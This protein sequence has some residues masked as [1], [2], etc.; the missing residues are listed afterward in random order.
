M[1]G[2][3]SLSDLMERAL[4]KATVIVAALIMIGIVVDGYIQGGLGYG[5][6]S[7][8]NL[9]AMVSNATPVVTVIMLW[10][11][12]RLYY[13]RARSPNVSMKLKGTFFFVG[14]FVAV[15]I[16]IVYGVMSSQYQNLAVVL[17][18]VNDET[19]SYWIAVIFT[20]LVV[21]GALVKSWEGVIIAVTCLAQVW[22]VGGVGNYLLPQL[23]DFGI[24]LM[25]WPGVGANNA[26][27]FATYIALISVCGRIMIG[28]QKLSPA[29]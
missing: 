22:G 29:R 6:W 24:W 17:R 12:F 21:R 4:P 8:K 1:E 9:N 14:F 7:M 15:G 11:W 2:L 13:R 26:L 23:G 20:S 16:A 10:S 18:R 28:K 25:R 19:G 3:D 27:W 5:P